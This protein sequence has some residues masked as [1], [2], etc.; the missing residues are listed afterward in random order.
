[1]KKLSILFTLIGFLF[2]SASTLS[3][4]KIGIHFVVDTEL[5]SPSGT[6]PEVEKIIADVNGY[7]SRS[8]VAIELFISRIDYIALNNNMNT[9]LKD[10][11]GQTAMDYYNSMP[12]IAGSPSYEVGTH[13]G[14]YNSREHTAKIHDLVRTSG[15]Y[16][17][18]Y[19]YGLVADGDPLYCGKAMT[20][21]NGLYINRNG[22]H[23]RIAASR[24]SCGS[25][26]VAHEIGHLMGLAHGNKVAECV[27]SAHKKGII[28]QA[29][30]WAEGNCDGIYQS[31]E[32]GTLMV[33]NWTNKVGGNIVP[34]FSSP[35]VKHYFC[36]SDNVC[37]HS[38]Y[39]N[40]VYTL[41]RYRGQYARKLP[42]KQSL[43][44]YNNSLR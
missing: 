5:G 18:S 38:R 14:N 35:N 42:S 40:A 12:D 3:A 21:N 29:R 1:M 16:N 8:G 43:E 33:H 31:G 44:D 13:S 19:I 2:F 39:G 26:T 28:T 4:T 15:D 41:N 10:L 23:S 25:D 22:K 36:G 20:V 6:T 27:G 7:Y 24:L 32:F 37:G 9:T 30:G 34:V 11:S 17:S